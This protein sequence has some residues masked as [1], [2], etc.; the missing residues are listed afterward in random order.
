MNPYFSC[1]FAVRFLLSLALTVILVVPLT[2]QSA[3][4]VLATSPLANSTTS[5]VLPNLMFVLDDS[6][7]MNWDYLPDLVVD[8][9]YCKGTAATG[10]S[11]RCCRKSSGTNQSSS[12]LDSVCLSTSSPS[13]ED[14]RGM[15]PFYSSSFNKVYYDP[16]VTYKVPVDY[17]GTNKTSYDGSGS[18]PLDAYGKQS[19]ASLSLTSSY[20]DVEWCTDSNYT[21]CLR[22]DNYLLPGVVNSKTYN[23][24]H[25]TTSSG[26]SLFATGSVAAPTASASRTVGPFYYV[27]IPGEYCSNRDLTNC[28]TASAPTTVSGTT[29]DVAA[30]LRWCA[31]SDR[32]NC[33]STQDSTYNYPRYPTIVTAAAIAGTATT[34]KITVGGMPRSARPSGGSRPTGACSAGSGGQTASTVAT[35]TSVQLNGVE[36]LTGAFTYCNGDSDQATRNNGLAAEIQSRVGN[37]FAASRSSAVLTITAPD[38]SYVGATLS[39]TLSGAPPT[40]II[41]TSF[42]GAAAAGPVSVPGSFQRVDIVSGQTYGN[43]VSGG[44]TIVN[45][46]ARSDC[47]AKP[48]CTYAEELANFANWFAWYRTR[49]QAMKTSVSRAFKTIDNRFRVGYYP[50]D[51]TGSNYLRIDTFSAGA[52][53]QKDLWYGK[54]FNATPSGSTPLRSALS[55]VGRIFA[56]KNPLGKSP[57]DDPVQYSCQQNFVL[58]TTDGYW[59]TDNATDVKDVSEGA[60]GNL[61]SE[62]GLRSSGMYE[63]PTASSGSLADTAKYYYD[64]D[65]RSSAFGNCTGALGGSIDVCANNVFRSGSD[66]NIQQHMTTYTLG[67]GVSGILNYSSDYRTATSGDYYKLTQGLPFTAGGTDTVNWP[68]PQMGSSSEVPARIDDL[69]HAAVNGH[70]VYF[71]ANNPNELASGLNE[72]LNSI[73][74]KV[75]SAAAA[76]TSTLNPVAGNNFA[77]VASYSTVKWTGNLEARSIDVNTGVV[78]ETATWCV[79]NI[80]AGTCTLPATVVATTSG[81]STIY[82]CVTPGATSSTCLSPSVLD[83][84][85]CKLEMAN[86]CTGTL[87]AKVAATTDTRV[88]KMR[89]SS[90][91]LVDFVD[92]NL[93]A[94]DFSGTGLSQ[95]AVL[96]DTQKTAAAANMVK[97]LRG[98]TGFED[99]ASN[100]VGNRLYRSREATLGDAVES[101]PSF[102]SKPVFS[103]SDPGYSA[104]VTAQASRAGTVYMGT[105]DGM[106][107][108]FNASTG[109]ERWAYVP[110]MVIPNMWKLA[111]KNYATLHTNF[112]NGSPTISDICTANCSC[113][114]ACVALGGSAPVWKTILVGGL[115]AGGR[116]YYALDITNPAA[117]VSLWEFTTGNDSDL[118]YSFGQP[119]ITKKSDVNGTWVVVVTSGY[120]NTS[121]GDGKGYLY[122]LNANTGVVINKI[123]TGVGSATTPSGLAK[124]SAWND[125]V[126]VN[127]TAGFVYGG[128]LLGNVWRFDIN[129]P[130]KLLFATLKDSSDN[131]QPVTTAP[132]L[133]KVKGNRVIFVGTGKYLETG[134]LATTAQQSLYAIKDNDSA[135]LANART[136]LVNQTLTNSTTTGTRI[137]TNNAVNFTT[138]RGWYV[139]FPDRGERQNI[140]SQLVQGTLIVPTIVPSAT[141]CSPGG[142]GWLNFLDYETGGFVIASTVGIKTDSPIVGINVIYIQ[143]VPKVS[144]VTSDKPTPEIIPGV[145]FKMTGSAFQ[146]VR[147][148]WREMIQ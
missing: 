70:G 92:S 30:T 108:A 111:D 135:T 94:S 104:F 31:N 12:G 35:V 16:A 46:S 113:N 105:N 133:G 78:S 128:D 72:A 20:P 21:D 41:T 120:N 127:N 80:V 47:A 119:I 96:D 62:P 54:L 6:G 85:N 137:G 142:Y 99:K 3:S 14:Y 26:N 11:Y 61:D 4:V 43:I 121:P 5:S 38:I 90:G 7:S 2:V 56:G 130:A 67:L 109:E 36:L 116:G 79:E 75:G 55:K 40:M 107:H 17:A 65:L 134:D 39:T 48:D 98:Q 117:P 83:G 13:T 139:D 82:N 71:G 81:S 25:K 131:A 19:T 59:N 138:G 100:V 32:T 37:G 15:P 125:F 145:S 86:A 110:S 122:V 76:A 136:V 93:V 73:G 66:N 126:G 115:N 9:N 51:S 8:G 89:D 148:M 124:I 64:T 103:Y 112:V 50:I 49:M 24:M 1:R 132:T 57:S 140:N 60:I 91:A 129:T 87:S 34:G 22:N 114:D 97:F 42:T 106:L 74:S 123:A 77:Y 63:G 118:G 84:T 28:V 52:G 10:T 18:V 95:W 23:T 45:R 69:W 143:G 146:G 88:I 68:D 144:V 27:M 29:Y 58:M 147:V 101:Q 102:I 33:K 141:V 53:A 44:Q